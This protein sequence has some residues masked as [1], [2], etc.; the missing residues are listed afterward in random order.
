M[1]KFKDPP[2]ALDYVVDSLI[3]RRQGFIVDVVGPAEDIT[4]HAATVQLLDQNKVYGDGEYGLT[5]HLPFDPESATH[6]SHEL[7]K[8]FASRGAFDEVPHA[9]MPCYAM[10]FGTDVPAALHMLAA[11][12]NKVFEYPELTAFECVVHE[13]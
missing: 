6:E 4:D 2:S 3:P 10:R 12:L 8:T 5:L 7:F 13:G 11:V 1:R 9:G